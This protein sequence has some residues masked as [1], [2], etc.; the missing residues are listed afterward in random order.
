MHNI[1]DGNNN[2]SGSGIIFQM[3]STEGNIKTETSQVTT[4]EANVGFEGVVDRYKL[5]TVDS[6]REVVHIINN[7][8]IIE[9]YTYS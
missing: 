5:V 7:L 9:S 4:E 2:N 1:H 6:S 3:T 8:I